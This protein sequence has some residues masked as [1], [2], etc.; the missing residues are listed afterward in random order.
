[1]YYLILLT[2][3]T[4]LK[5]RTV[6]P[7]YIFLGE[8]KERKKKPKKFTTVG[9]EPLTLYEILQK[10]RSLSNVMA[11]LATRG[12][13]LVAIL[14]SLWPICFADIIQENE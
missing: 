4:K 12:A 8:K 1:M 13:Q 7:V 5:Q 2:V 9:A 3:N 11:P 6:N 14:S 10:N